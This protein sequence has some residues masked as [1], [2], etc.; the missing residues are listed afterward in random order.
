MPHLRNLSSL[1]LKTEVLPWDFKPSQPIPEEVRTNKKLRDEWINNP[2]TDHN[3]YS[4]CEGIN[5]SA[6]ISS[7]KADESGNPV[8]R[9]WAIVADYDAGGNLEEVKKHLM[10]LGFPPNW[11]EKT[12][13]G[14]WRAVWL[15]EE[16]L[17]FASTAFFKHFMKGFET[18]GFSVSMGW[19]GFDQG[20][21]IAPERMYTNSCE[22]YPIHDKKIPADVTRGWLF[23]ASKKFT[24]DRSQFGG[25]VIPLDAVAARLRE[26]NPRFEAEWRMPFEVGQQGPSFFVEGSVS[27][28][29]AIIHETGI[30]TF[31]MHAAKGFYTWADLLGIDFC[32]TYEAKATGRAVEGIYH[33]S[34]LYHRQ[35]PEGCWRGF[36][37]ADI[38]NHLIAARGV[39]IT[40][41]KKGGPSQVQDCI[42][43]IQSYQ[44]VKGAAPFIY[45]PSGPIQ[46]NGERYLNTSDVK[47]MQPSGKGIWGVDGNF[48]WLSKFLDGIFTSPEQLAYFLAWL[49]YAWQ[50][51]YLLDPVS[52]QAMFIVG[53]AGVGKTLL[54]RGII[55]AVLGGFVDATKYY[56][57]LDNFGSQ[58]FEKGVH[59]ID[60]AKVSTDPKTMKMFTEGIKEAVA[61][62]EQLYHKKFGVPSMAE[63]QGRIVVTCNG[64]VISVRI[65]PNLDQ[66]IMDKLIILKA[67]EFPFMKF[68][69][70]RELKEILA[71]ELPNFCAW[72]RDH[73]IPEEL[74]GDSRFGIKCYLEPSIV[75]SSLQSSENAGFNEILDDWKKS[76][77]GMREP[78]AKF[79]EG[80]AYQLLKA[81][82][83]DQ[84]AEG[85]IRRLS[86]ERVGQHLAGLMKNKAA[87]IKADDSGSTRIWKI[88]RDSDS[89]KP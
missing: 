39:S 52:G 25:L 72:L 29:S 82:N 56:M 89:K 70:A 88:F 9:C 63:N 49:A 17:Q 20:A 43:Y 36:E 31:S 7:L 59:C 5:G 13:S 30:Q 62:K 42:E 66:G 28:K 38:V 74:L 15:L 21:F 61:N 68:P 57:G 65:I 45:R 16:P 77:F 12:L 26:T 37:K 41:V 84:S 86:V 60:D 2:A 87:N 47:V 1:D 75:R 11:I 4:F 50:N 14:H 34:K 83:L 19:M 58:L 22:W 46:F 53:G 33:D 44:G 24:F 10:Q 73:K 23:A 32:R 80:T 35:L 71:R 6:R 8:F 55:G 81:F 76:Y 18:F 69:T 85:I 27:P 78:E 51:A 67:Q 40:P 48:P 79:W 64:D 3:V 54:S